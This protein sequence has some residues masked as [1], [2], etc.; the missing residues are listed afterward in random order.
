MDIAYGAQGKKN[1]NFCWPPSHLREGKTD[2]DVDGV[3]LEHGEAE[4]M[5]IVEG[6]PGVVVVVAVDYEVV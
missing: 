1:S 5:V 4:A 2:I 3:V 6:E